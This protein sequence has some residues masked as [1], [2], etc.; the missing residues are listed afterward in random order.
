MKKLLFVLLSMTLCM[1][2]TAVT[3]RL[4][5]KMTSAGNRVDLSRLKRHD[6]LIHQMSSPVMCGDKSV[7]PLNECFTRRGVT[8]DDNLMMKKAPRR[9]SAQDLLTTK[10]AF[11]EC[12]EYDENT[13]EVVRAA[14]YYD[15]GWDVEMEQ[16]GDGLFGAYI[17]YSSIP[18]NILVDFNTNTAEMIMD[19][20]GGWQWA[21]SIVSGRT[22]T[23]ND[24]TMYLFMVDEAYMM[25]DSDEFTNISGTVYSDGSLYFPDGWCYV[26]V[27][28]VTKTVTD[29]NGVTNTTRD[30]VMSMTPFYHDT[31]LMTPNATH[32]YD[33]EYQIGNRTYIDHYTDNAYMFQFDDS[34][35]VAWN[36]WGCGGRG[37]FMNIHEDGTMVI[38]AFQIAG[39]VDMTEYEE[40]YPEYDWSEGYENVIVGYDEDNDTYYYSD[41]MGTVSPEGLTW[42][43]SELWNYCS[44]DGN[45]YAVR[46][47]PLLN[48]VLSFVDGEVFLLGTSACPEITLELFDGHVLVAA[49][50]QGVG[51]CAYLFDSNGRM[52]DNPCTVTRTEEDQHLMF[53]A[54]ES[55]PGKNMSELMAQEVIV[56]ALSSDAVVI[57]DVNGD[58]TVN[59]QD[60]VILIDYLLSGDLDN[61]GNF[62]GDNADIDQNNVI[63]LDDVVALMNMIIEAD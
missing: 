26:M 13:G 20:M 54:V 59:L 9:I 32:D 31:Y 25:G 55:D 27:N 28:Y 22:K 18:A 38:P 15:G 37:V 1:A 10:V 11:K 39:T 3:P 51:G 5:G 61:S 49:V 36:L 17:D 43:G 44:L 14:C 63:N 45:T 48:N 30:T 62:I 33:L 35:A 24:T 56:P 58:N 19:C 40:A 46:S 60:V 6:F 34:T 53:F 41:I 8:P 42:G 23:V 50:P 2:A 21:D 29:Y 52:V 4:Q 57:G 7:L 12:F 16:M 47:Y